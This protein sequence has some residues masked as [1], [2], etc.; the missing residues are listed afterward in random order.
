[1]FS[2]RDFSNS[3]ENV[4]W[5]QKNVRSKICSAEKDFGRKIKEIILAIPDSASST[6]TSAFSKDEPVQFGDQEW[7][8]VVS[9]QDSF[10]DVPEADRQWIIGGAGLLITVL[11]ALLV[12]NMHSHTV[13]A[14]AL[15]TKRTRELTMSEE[16]LRAIT[17]GSPALIAIIQGDGTTTY[18]NRPD[19][20]SDRLCEL[21]DSGH[22]DILGAI[23]KNHKALKVE[24]S[25]NDGKSQHFNS[26]SY[27]KLPDG[28]ERVLLIATD[29]TDYKRIEE[30]L[31]HSQKLNA[32]GQLAGGVAHDFNN[33]LAGILSSAE[34]L[35]KY[36]PNDPKALRFQK[37]IMESAE[38][39]AGL[40]RKLLAFAR[41][42]QPASSVIDLHATLLDTIAL[43][44]STIDRRVEVVVELQAEQHRIVGDPAQLQSAILNLGINAS[45]AM[46]DGGTIIFSTRNVELD[47]VYCEISPFDLTPGMYLELE[48]RDTGSGISPAD[49]PRIF[50]PF[51][52][53]KEQGKGTGLGLAAVYGTVQQHK[54]SVTVY[55]EVGNGTCFH[56]SLPLADD[57]RVSKSKSQAKLLKGTGLILLVDDEEHMRVTAQAILE[58]LGY[59]VMTA[60]NGVEGLECFKK[61]NSKIDLVILDMVMPQMNG[62]DCFM[63]IRELAPNAKVILSSGFS[64]EEDLD[65]MQYHGLAGFIRKPFRSIALSEVVYEALES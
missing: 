63:A 38:R 46:P 60:C 64:R 65:D 5:G 48:V 6:E 19:E 61:H 20:A 52:T 27:L 10:L 12:H 57:E 23:L 44:K 36:L 62:R 17:E 47:K 42:Q 40:T 24:T 1:M 45:H 14:E 3:V 50:E 25:S 7:R 33:V 18:T 35:E 13:R 54:G 2:Q 49:M 41:R 51:F 11:L 32:I 43:L 28:S 21:K 59:D 55:S 29:I 30:Q 53:T 56:L 37:I 26:L 22:G 15:V 8:L 9:A 39:A 31:Q 4:F 16:R 58:E 34:L